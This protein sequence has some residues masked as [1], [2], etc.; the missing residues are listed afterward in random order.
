MNWSLHQPPHS[1]AGLH[2]TS[3]PAAVSPS[4][5]GSQG[6][7]GGGEGGCKRPAAT[8][9]RGGA[10]RREGLPRGHAGQAFE[11]SFGIL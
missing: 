2:I 10:V 5:P 11:A 1:A 4:E 7:L 8:V 3:S 6:V 9:H